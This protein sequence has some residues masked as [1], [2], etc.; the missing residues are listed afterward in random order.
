[1]PQFSFPNA[2]KQIELERIWERASRRSRFAGKVYLLVAM[3]FLA[4]LV[5]YESFAPIETAP[6]RELLAWVGSACLFPMSLCWMVYCIWVEWY[7][8][9]RLVISKGHPGTDPNSPWR[10]RLS[11]Y[12]EFA[13]LGRG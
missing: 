3:C 8:Y 4:G 6:T 12:L 5:K 7:A 13:R 2:T 10:P 1:M 9:R 11:L